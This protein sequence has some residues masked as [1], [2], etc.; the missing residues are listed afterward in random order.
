MLRLANSFRLFL[1]VVVLGLS[2]TGLAQARQSRDL[3]SVALAELPSEVS[4]TLRLIRRHGPFPYP[5][6]DDGIF[7]NFE[8]RLPPQPRGYYREYTVP[9]PGSRTRGARRII[10]GQGR[11]GDVATSGEYYYTDDHYRNFRRIR[12]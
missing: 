2:I 11:N 12:D 8:R 7:G 5:R 4:Q 10:A 9:T 1:L 3:T 6:N